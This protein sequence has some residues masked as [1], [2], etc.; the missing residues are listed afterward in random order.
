MKTLTNTHPDWLF[1]FTC[2]DEW[3]SRHTLTITGKRF[4]LRGPLSQ[5]RSLFASI[6]VEVHPRL[7]R[8][9]DEVLCEYKTIRRAFRTFRVLTHTRT[10]L[11]GKQAIQVDTAYE[12][13]APPPGPRSRM[14]TI[15]ER[16]ILAVHEE[17]TYQICYRAASEDFDDSLPIFDALVASFRL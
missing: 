9:L 15:R 12:M 6:T 14:I 16:V 2:P 17:R 7:K 4:F 3:E 11:A 1:S 10:K 8:A 5:D 13:P